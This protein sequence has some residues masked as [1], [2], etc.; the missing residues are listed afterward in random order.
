MTEPTTALPSSMTPGPSLAEY[1]RLDAEDDNTFWRLESGHHQNL[2][3]EAI[4]Q[5]DALA[6]DL[7]EE[8]A[9][10][11]NF[12]SAVALHVPADGEDSAEAIIIDWIKNAV[13]ALDKVHAF[14]HARGEFVGVLRQYSG[15]DMAD[16]HRWTGHAEARRELAE[17]LGLEIDQQNG[18]LL[19]GREA[20]RG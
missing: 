17:T 18:G 10:H 2:L 11:E 19:H 8:R 13:A 6:A 4:D 3:E 15:E 14:V 7:A 1:R 9:A 16:Y 20:D 5:I 12:V